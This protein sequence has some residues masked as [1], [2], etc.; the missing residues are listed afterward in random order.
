MGKVSQAEQDLGEQPWYL[1][2]PPPFEGGEVERQPQHVPLVPGLR[3]QGQEGLCAF[4]ASLV[5]VVSS[6]TQGYIVKPCLKRVTETARI[7]HYCLCSGWSQGQDYDSSPSASVIAAILS[8]HC[9]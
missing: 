4:E 2:F 9:D 6:S 7:A 1:A 5:Y 3:W 8:T